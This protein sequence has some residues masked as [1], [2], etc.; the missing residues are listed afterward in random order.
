MEQ[1][2][3]IAL[4]KGR[5]REF[6]IDGALAAALTV[7]WRRGYESASMTEL[8]SAMGITKPSLYAAFGN[9]EALFHKALDLYE[10]EK[11][12]YVGIALQEPTARLVAEKLLLG[13]LEMQ[14]GTSDPKGCLAVIASVACGCES[15]TIKADIAARRA[16]SNAALVARFEQAKKN[17]E[18]P[19]DMAADALANYLMSILQGLSVQASGGASCATLRQ[20]VATSMSV[21]PTR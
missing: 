9:K 16:S 13:A 8:T 15:D 10:R 4:P 19:D 21:W 20:L 12:A 1:D 11:L 3:C 7:F 18:L 14:S 17:G 5:P 6:C 2:G